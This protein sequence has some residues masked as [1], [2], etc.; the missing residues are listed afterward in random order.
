MMAS[1]SFEDVV[2][3]NLLFRSASVTIGLFVSW[4]SGSRGRSTISQISLGFDQDGTA[5]RAFPFASS[6]VIRHRS[7]FIGVG[8]VTCAFRSPPTT[9]Q[10]RDGAACTILSANHTFCLS[11]SRQVVEGRANQREVH[12]RRFYPYGSSPSLYA[13]LW[14]G[15]FTD[16]PGY[17]DVQF[18]CDNETCMSICPSSHPVAP[19]EKSSSTRHPVSHRRAVSTPA[20]GF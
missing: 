17:A 15:H 19:L 14:R 2:W 11:P 10:H 20:S 6:F 3:S 5:R 13:S 8:A 18:D 9:T 4:M 1:N 7:F 16:L 12:F